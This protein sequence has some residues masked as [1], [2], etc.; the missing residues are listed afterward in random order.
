L[1]ADLTSLAAFARRVLVAI[2]LVALAC[3]LWRAVD[4]L[5]L[6]LG[7]V[8]V[9][10]LLRAGAEPIARRTR[11]PDR[12]AV[13]AVAIVI[14]VA[15]VLVG[16]LVGTE[17]NAQVSDLLRRLP[18]AW[19]GLQ[20]RLGVSALGGWLRSPTEAITSGTGGVL[21]S[22]AGYASTLGGALANLI[23]VLVGGV[24][25]A[26][27]PDLYRTGL[28]K[29]VPGEAARARV[30]GTLE[31]CGRALRAW[32]LG[33][34]ASM[35]IVGALTWL[36]LG[37]IGVPAAFALALLALLAEFVPIV[38]PIIATVPAL[39]LALTQGWDAALWTLALYLAVQQ[40][41]SNLITPVVQRE[42]VELPPALTLFGVVGVGVV[43]GP[44][45]LI[46]AV[47]ALVIA[48]V[49]TKKLWVRET[50]HEPT[51]VPGEDDTRS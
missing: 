50:L 2:A 28:L 38:G 29:L 49:A 11:V 35:A 26:T 31:A 25:L 42:T 13:A 30:A 27:H 33:Q 46:L 15:L 12:W 16:W 21:A 37:L 41:E 6:V 9:A 51:P 14:L 23:L 39:L 45:G 1:S 43:F 7:G 44:L 40:V 5:F 17:V 34:L 10:V 24:F 4:V 20:Q 18:Q 8:V 48:Y 32:L 36:G 47:P 22:L 3:L 19:Q